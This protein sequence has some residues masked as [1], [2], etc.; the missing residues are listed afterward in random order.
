MT[1][2]KITNICWIVEKQEFQGNI[3][4]CFIDYTKAF[5]YVGHN[6]LENSWRENYQTILP[7]SW[8]TCMQDK[9]QQLEP[10]V[11]QQTVQNWEKS[12]SRLYGVTLLT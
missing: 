3:Y 6:K 7:V 11:E 8:E 12:M 10:D 9:K 5:D 1:R 2:G 4:F